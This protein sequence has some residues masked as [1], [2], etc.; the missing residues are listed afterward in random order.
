MEVNLLP[1]QVAFIEQNVKAGRFASSD[2]AIREALEMLEEHER[3]LE[4]LRAAI[5][6]SDADYAAGRYT[7]WTDETLPEL[8]EQIKRE[9]RALRETRAGLSR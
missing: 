6:E 7:E 5:D 3:K 4:E 8:F 1:E 2:E 9:G